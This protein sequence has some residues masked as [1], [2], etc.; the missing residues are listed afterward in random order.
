MYASE[1]SYP[2][3]LSPSNSSAVK[4]PSSHDLPVLEEMY[5]FVLELESCLCSLIIDMVMASLSIPTR[6]PSRIK[7][8]GGNFRYYNTC[9]LCE[10]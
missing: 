6:V 1:F 9:Q 3:S 4:G 5:M 10:T 8:L 7:V 2:C